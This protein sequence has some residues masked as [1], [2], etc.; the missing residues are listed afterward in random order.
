MK[1]ANGRLL[2]AVD[3]DGT[4]L[5]TEF[6]DILRPRE[7][8]AMQRVRDA[9]HVLALCTGRNLNSTAA[10]LENSGWY[11]DDLP[12]VL[13]NGAVVWGGQPRRC[14]KRNELDGD[15]IRAL[16]GL[17][18]EHDT[19][20]MV[21]GSDDDGGVLHHEK[22]LTNDVLGQYLSKRRS[23]VGAITATDDLGG[24]PWT[25]ALE[26]GTIDT[27]DRI[28]A[29]TTAIGEQV[30]GVR[31]INTRSLLGQGRYYWAEAFDA[32]SDKGRGL[33]VLAE[34]CGIPL[35]DTVAI[36]DNYNDLDMFETAAVSVAMAGSPDE[37]LAAAD[38]VTGPVKEGGAAQV[39]ERIADGERP[40]ASGWKGQS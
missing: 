12:M 37:V 5:D 15:R 25:R 35:A 4:L 9:G 3:V 2:I 7:V 23:A 38:H 11:P 34:E 14:I 28:D 16:I 19:V 10:L 33:T 21:Y 40:D 32:G 29:L 24:L 17:F 31:V 18:K 13:L 27:R 39:L 30:P 1:K 36:G 22:R 6:E 20:P 8:E 26:V